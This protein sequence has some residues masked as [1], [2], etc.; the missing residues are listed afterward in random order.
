MG[1]VEARVA[2]GNDVNIHQYT[3][4]WNCNKTK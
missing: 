1:R 3:Q 2:G 4:V